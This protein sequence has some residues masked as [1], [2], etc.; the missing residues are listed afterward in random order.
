MMLS[1]KL[2]RREGLFDWIAAITISHTKGFPRRL[3]CSS[4]SLASL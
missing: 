3:S 2:G 4:I 1:S